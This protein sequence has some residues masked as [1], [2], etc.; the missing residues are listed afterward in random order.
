V[1][2]IWVPSDAVVAIHR[3]LLQEDGGLFGPP[4]RDSLE[5]ALARLRQL[6]HYVGPKPS[7]PQLAAAHGF[8]LAKGHCGLPPISRTPPLDRRRH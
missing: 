2:P 8:A 3:A 1:T 6:H 5:A 4:R 7:L